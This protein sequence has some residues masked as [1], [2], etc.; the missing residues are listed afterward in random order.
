LSYGAGVGV[1]RTRLFVP[2]P[3]VL[4]FARF[5]SIHPWP[6]TI[7]A[8]TLT[9]KMWLPGVVQV[10]DHDLIRPTAALAGSILFG[11]V[12]GLLPA[13]AQSWGNPS[14][15]VTLARI[16]GAGPLLCMF[17]IADTRNGNP[18]VP[19]CAV[20]ATEMTFTSVPG[21]GVGVG[22]GVGDGDGEGDGEGLGVGDA[23]GA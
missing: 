15:W 21:T 1:A 17:P 20:T 13:A 18:A 22:A 19:D 14:E 16:L 23:V 7:A 5:E 2:L 12:T 8:C 4:L 11:T 9:V 6:D 3:K 10:T